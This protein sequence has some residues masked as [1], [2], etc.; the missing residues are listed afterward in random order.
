MGGSG[1][2]GGRCGEQQ[3]RR[4]HRVGKELSA[5]SS[6]GISAGQR[7]PRRGSVRDRRSPAARS[8]PGALGTAAA[9]SL[10]SRENQTCK[11]GMAAATEAQ[12]MGREKAE[13]LPGPGGR[14]RQGRQKEGRSGR[15]RGQ[16]WWLR[17]GEQGQRRGGMIGPEESSPLAGRSTG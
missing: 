10:C 8:P 13:G 4:H 14:G 1:Q 16:R 2:L 11:E 6:G 9:A 7:E 3:G 15:G 5:R 12:R 17:G